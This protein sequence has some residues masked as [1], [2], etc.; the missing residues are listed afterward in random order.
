M[1]IMAG[2][3]DTR[4]QELG[5]ELPAA[6]APAANYVPYVVA[7][8]TLY[9]AGQ[10]SMIADG[11]KF[12]GKVGAEIDAETAY[13]AARVCGLNILAQA[14]AALG[15]LDRIERCV[16]LGGFVN[17]SPDFTN[18]PEVVNGASDL[19]VEVLGDN[20][21]HARFAVGCGSLPRNVQVEIDAIFAVSQ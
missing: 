15:D 6:P 9:V 4:L 11:D 16:K 10:V 19:M 5:I 3:I 12:L 20:G 8:T 1:S 17:A 18:H 7:G 14:K 21:K 2:S 13:Q